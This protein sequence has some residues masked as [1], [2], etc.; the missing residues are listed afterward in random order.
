MVETISEYN[1][2]ISKYFFQPIY[3]DN[4]NIYFMKNKFLNL[5]EIKIKLWYH[6]PSNIKYE[7]KALKRVAEKI[8]N[9]SELFFLFRETN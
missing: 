1:R 4:M 8:F 9:S 6:S 2:I 3:L 7:I 5:N